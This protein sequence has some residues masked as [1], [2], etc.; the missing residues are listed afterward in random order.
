M[1]TLVEFDP[2]DTPSASITMKSI[3]HTEKCRF[4]YKPVFKP[5]TVRSLYY[6]PTCRD[7]H[8]KLLESR[9]SSRRRDRSLCLSRGFGEPGLPE[10]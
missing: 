2:A 6:Q 7:R 4:V 10:R 3:S 5:A 8:S 9:T 1:K